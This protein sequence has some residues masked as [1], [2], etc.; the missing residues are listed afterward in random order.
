M[1]VPAPQLSQ[2]LPVSLCGHFPGTGRS[3]WGRDGKLEAAVGRAGRTGATG[4]WLAE[5]ILPGAPARRRRG[6]TTPARPCLPA[7][8]AG[9]GAHSGEQLPA[10]PAEPSCPQ[11][12]LHPCEERAFQ[13]TGS[14]LA[15]VLARGPGLP[16][17]LAAERGAG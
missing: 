8:P 11:L 16:G 5:L 17:G 15:L 2:V 6:G 9:A 7:E 10:D 13:P 1:A 4:A 3:F 12:T 14:A